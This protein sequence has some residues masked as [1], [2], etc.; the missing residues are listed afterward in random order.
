MAYQNAQ[1]AQI[2]LSAKEDGR[3]TVRFPYT[4]KRVTK[5][6]TV[7]GRRWDPREKYWTIPHTDEAIAE[8]HTAFQGESVCADPGI[9]FGGSDE[10]EPRFVRSMVQEM[11]EAVENVFKLRRYS[12]QTRK[13]YRPHIRRFLE[14]L[15]KPA[16]EATPEEVHA[17]FLKLVDEDQMSYSYH[18]DQ[19]DPIPVYLRPGKA[20]SSGESP[21]AQ[22]GEEAA[23]GVGPRSD[24]AVAGR[25]E[26]PQARGVAPG[27][28][29]I[30]TPR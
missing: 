26:Q 6:R 18:S 10:S 29:F 23:R 14:H 21:S 15:G 7:A 24:C 13:S 11:L 1:E 2:R 12:F 17:Y 30:R 3:I 20:L 27:R 5:I 8:L 4:P 16:R 25:R 9:H 28:L 19:R 22:V